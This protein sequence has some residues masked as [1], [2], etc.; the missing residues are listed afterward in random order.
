MKGAL[1]IRSACTVLLHHGRNVRAIGTLGALISAAL[2]AA[3]GVQSPIQNNVFLIAL[4]MR[5]TRSPQ[6]P[7]PGLA[8]QP[9]GDLHVFTVKNG[10]RFFCRGQRC[11]VEHVLRFTGYTDLNVDPAL[12][13]NNHGS[14][15]GLLAEDIN[16]RLALHCV[17]WRVFEKGVL[18]RS[19]PQ[20]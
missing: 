18:V 5:S 2:P 6:H 12:A 9:M 7:A 10:D 16:D 4:H 15:S 1:A 14:I 17:S 11:T 13:T 19:D 20:A 8:R 3:D